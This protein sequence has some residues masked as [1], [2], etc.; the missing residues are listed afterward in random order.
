VP[1]AVVADAP[2][3]A[4][5][6]DE[7]VSE[8]VV[9]AEAAAVEVEPAAAAGDEADV[10]GARLVALNM[11]L[12]GTSRDETAKYLADNFDLSDRAALLDEVYAA[13]ES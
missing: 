10:E 8:E 6:E 7:R 5:V 3:P 9:V 1:L 2:P 12:N 13:V 11:A 4:P